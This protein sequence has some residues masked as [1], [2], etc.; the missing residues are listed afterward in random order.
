MRARAEI[1]KRYATE[2]A[3]AP[4]HVKSQILDEV[5]R[6][7]DWSRDNARRRLTAKASAPPGRRRK[8]GPRPGA[9]RY[10]YDALKILQKVWAASG[11][12][13]GKYLAASMAVLLANLEAH[14]H[15]VE[16]KARYSAGVRAELEAMSA[17][18]IDRY[19]APAKARDPLRGKSATR[20]GTMLRNSITVRKA[21]DEAEDEPGFFEVDT[22]AH[23]GPTLKGEFA[24][25]VNFTDVRTGWVFTV[26]IRN[27]ARVHMLAALDAAQRAVPYPL[28]GLDCDNGSEFINH[29][30]VEWA[31][32]RDLF[33][34]R[35]RPYR[36]NDQATVE[37][38]NNHLVRRYG[39]YW[40]YD[41]A[42]EREVLN[43]LWRLVNDRLNY[44]TPTR[45]P[46]GWS[47]DRAGRRRRLYDAPATPLERLL[48]A[49]VLSPAQERELLAK[50]DQL[51]VMALAAEIDRAQRQL[52][53]LAAG[54]TRRLE[55][56][57]KPKL[58][59]PKG[60]KPR[61]SPPA[62]KG[63]P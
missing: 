20:P 62:A 61:G 31:A 28:A 26:A 8:P 54:K 11:G 9:R 38:K 53:K 34:T 17:S 15:L 32:Q 21:S 60:I 59:D 56:Q 22:V 55:A 63:T 16:G 23:C 48:A 1:A 29:E 52:I 46:V 33:F 39:M 36:K 41:T 10:S 40:R 58:P 5:V 42:P 45:K 30:V 57:A 44:F 47:T 19:L 14:G 35:S 12:Q 50:R 25:S 4:K 6:V 3:R 13:C 27:N 43:R 2:Y 18:T 7:T 37:S 24:R 49:G 51:D